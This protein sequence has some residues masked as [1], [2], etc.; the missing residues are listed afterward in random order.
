MLVVFDNPGVVEEWAKKVE[1]ERLLTLEVEEVLHDGDEVDRR[2]F[3][4]TVDAS[5]NLPFS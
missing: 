1:K 3:H 5:I 2:N 4:A